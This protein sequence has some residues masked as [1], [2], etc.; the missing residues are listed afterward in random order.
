MGGMGIGATVIPTGP[1]AVCFTT[2]CAISTCF[3]KVLSEERK[4]A[5]KR[6]Y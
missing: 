5:Y 6:V 4:E 3:R 2:V 1:I